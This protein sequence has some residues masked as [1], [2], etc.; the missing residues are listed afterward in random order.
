MIG[1]MSYGLS[2]HSA[3]CP[4]PSSLAE[5]MAARACLAAKAGVCD[6]SSTHY[7]HQT[8]KVDKKHPQMLNVWRIY[9]HLAIFYVQSPLT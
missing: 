2:Y 9:L 1:L 3:A 8:N 5:A 4:W 6:E 7:I